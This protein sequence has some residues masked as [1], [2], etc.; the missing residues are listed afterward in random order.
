MSVAGAM[1][2][3]DQGRCIVQ[4]RCRRSL[5]GLTCKSPD[6]YVVSAAVAVVA[7]WY[8]LQYSRPLRGLTCSIPDRTC[9]IPDCY[10]V[11]PVIILSPGQ[12]LWR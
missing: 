4:K 8:H 6:R 10:V 7:A 5:C 11:S 3:Q 1:R 12:D 2:G 9:S